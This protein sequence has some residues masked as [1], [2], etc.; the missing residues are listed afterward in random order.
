MRLFARIALSASGSL[1]CVFATA[2]SKMS[3][4]ARLEAFVAQSL[5]SAEPAGGRRMSSSR[6]WAW[7]WTWWS[8][9]SRLEPALDKVA[10][11]LC[12]HYNAGAC[13]ILVEDERQPS[14]WARSRTAREER[15]QPLVSMEPASGSTLSRAM[16]DARTLL[17]D[18]LTTTI[19]FRTA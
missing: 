17:I 10:A 15:F 14:G 4:T 19:V 8:P 11:A 5:T 7:P 6:R 1:V 3:A 2:G 18:D 9:A 16:R 13:L 12:A